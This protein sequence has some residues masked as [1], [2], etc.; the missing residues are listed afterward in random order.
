MKLSIDEATEIFQSIKRA[1]ELQDV[2]QVKVGA[3]S[4]TTDARV[5]SNPNKLVI[6]FDG[7]LGYTR[8]IAKRDDVTTALT[9]F[10]NRFGLR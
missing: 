6:V 2:I 9:E 1:C 5:K 7:P 4:W 3:L 8:D 10:T